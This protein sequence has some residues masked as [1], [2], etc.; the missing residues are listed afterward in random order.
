MGGGGGN[1]DPRDPGM[2]KVWGGGGEFFLLQAG[3]GADPG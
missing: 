3:W 1:Q 2:G